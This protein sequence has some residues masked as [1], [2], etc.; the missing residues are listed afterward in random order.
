MGQ[1]FESR[2]QS[3]EPRAKN[4]C[5]ALKHTQGKPDIF[6]L[7]FQNH[8]LRIPCSP[9]SPLNKNVL[10]FYAHPTTVC[11]VWQGREP[12]PGFTGAQ[13]QRKCAQ[14]LG[15]ILFCSCT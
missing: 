14:K 11:W 2:V 10:A 15:F 12:V 6:L 7:G 5:L 13:G 4:H 8:E 1:K 3:A 9:S